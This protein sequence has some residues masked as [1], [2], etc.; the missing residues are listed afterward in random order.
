MGEVDG[1]A[2]DS[3]GAL[4]CYSGEAEFKESSH[5]KNTKPKTIDTRDCCQSSDKPPNIPLLKPQIQ[6]CHLANLALNL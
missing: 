6:A 4:Q 1:E 2:D 3:V 5:K